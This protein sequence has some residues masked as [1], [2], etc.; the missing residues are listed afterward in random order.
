MGV[1]EN[2]FILGMALRNIG[3]LG[4]DSETGFPFVCLIPST[5]AAAAAGMNVAG[6]FKARNLKANE[7][8][9]AASDA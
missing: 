3:I 8:C 7:D 1:L 4:M 5:W 2:P 9:V 6:P